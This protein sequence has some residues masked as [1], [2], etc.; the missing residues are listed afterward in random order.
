MRNNAQQS[1]LL[2]GTGTTMVG[3]SGRQTRSYLPGQPE[4]ALVVTLLMVLVI[5][6][7]VQMLDS[8]W[9][10]DAANLIGPVILGL[11]TVLTGYRLVH[12]QPYAIW[13]PYSWFLGG[14]LLFYSLGPLVYMF[15]S[16]A[17]RVYLDNSLPIVVTSNDLLRTNILNV[18]GIS[19]ILIGFKLTRFIWIGPSYIY[20]DET[21]SLKRVKVLTLWLLFLG[22][23]LQ[24]FV[25]LPWEFGVYDFILPGTIFNLNKLF[26]FGLVGMAYVTTRGAR[27]W[28]LPFYVL[29][30]LQ[31]LISLLHFS[32]AAVL[33]SLILPVLGVYLA[34]QNFKRLLISG[35][36]TVVV[37][38][39]VA[40]LV[41]YGRHEIF[42]IS[43][44]TNQATLSQRLEILGRW[45]SGEAQ[46][47]EFA[48]SD[49]SDAE[50][51]WARLSYVNVQT[52]AMDRYDSGIP[53]DTLE[54]TLIVLIPRVLWSDKPVTTDLGKDFYELV[55]GR[56]LDTSLGV[57]LFAEGYWNLGW[58]GVV[59]L[60]VITGAI[61]WVLSGYA[62]HW[63]QNGAIEYLPGIF[64]GINMGILGITDFFA[65]AI[66]G[67]TGFIVFYTYF[68][69]KVFGLMAG[70]SR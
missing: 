61:F 53:G 52:Y 56:R 13:T 9:L 43:G 66:V 22:G 54:K 69:S 37:Y 48:Q 28:K 60:G 19:S 23:A 18:V 67:S 57:G 55:T 4:T 59:L 11:I 8:P 25:I 6:L 42:N 58:T 51:G 34:N 12:R 27:A 45:I 49:L 17:I 15:G 7:T 31:V 46:T 65:N 1:Q 62:I 44:T 41:H 35:F 26:L 5:Y 14:V 39:S 40:Q 33:L 47:F 32:K 64:L 63:L 24:Y 3:H 36:I 38:I 16:N 30:S 70:K 10:V 29:W 68:I 20:A 21:G 50:T 2:T